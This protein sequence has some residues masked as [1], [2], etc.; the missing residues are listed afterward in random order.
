LIGALAIAILPKHRQVSE[1]V[2]AEN[3][4]NVTARA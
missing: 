3:P 2:S 4:V 1:P